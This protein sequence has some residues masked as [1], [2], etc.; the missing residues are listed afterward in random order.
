M[1]HYITESITLEVIPTQAMVE[2]SSTSHQASPDGVE[3]AFPLL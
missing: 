1:S 3:D 2:T